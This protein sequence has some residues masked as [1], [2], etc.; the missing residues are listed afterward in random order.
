MNIR[1]I[2]QMFRIIFRNKT[3]SILNVAGLAI[4]IA[5]AALILL[6]VEDEMNYN[7]FPKQKQL[8]VLYQNQTYNTDIYTIP[9]APNPLAAALKE[10]I[11]GIKDVTRYNNGVKSVFP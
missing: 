9:M 6:W 11:P 1:Q 5:C 3:F 2:T 7:N 4:G 10:E 8:Y